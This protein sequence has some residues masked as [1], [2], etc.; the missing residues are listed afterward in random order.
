M[1]RSKQN[2]VWIAPLGMIGIWKLFQYGNTSESLQAMFMS[3]V[4]GLP[5]DILLYLLVFYFA[6]WLARSFAALTGK[7]SQ[8]PVAQVS[9]SAQEQAA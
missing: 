1:Y 6:R 9:P 3:L 4:R 5:Q 2:Q 7:N 8:L